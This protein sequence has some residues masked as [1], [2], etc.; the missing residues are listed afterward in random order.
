MRAAGQAAPVHERLLEMEL[1]PALLQGDTREQWEA[2]S[3]LDSFF[4]RVYAYFE[5]R[6]LRC[7]L[8]GRVIQL[9]TLAFTLGLAVCLADA[10]NWEGL[11][12]ECKDEH[13]CAAVQ[14]L[15][16][17]ALSA[18]S[19]FLKLFVGVFALYWLWM[20]L[21]FFWDLRP[22][23]EMRAFYR[24]KLRIV[25][26]DLQVV[27]WDLVVQRVVELQATSRLCI[28]KDQL[29][30]HDIANRILRKEN[31]MVAFVNRGLLPLELPMLPSLNMLT[32]TLEWNVY[33]C[34]LEAMFDSEF[35]IRQSFTQ[36]VTGLRRRLVLT[37]VLNLLLSPFIAA[38]MLIFFFL[39]HAEEFH[40]RPASSAFSRDYSSRARWMMREFNELPHIFEARML[41][42]T[43]DANTYVEQFPAPLL[44][45]VARFV[46]FI[47][48]S[49]VGVLILLSL[50]NERV[51][52]FYLH[53]FNLFWWLSMASVLLAVSRTFSAQ[54]NVSMHPEALLQSVARHTHY[55]PATWRQRGHT[56]QVYEEFARLYQY[57]VLLLLQEILG[58]VITPLLLCFVLPR[59]APD[60]L[61]FVRAFTVHVEGVGH[62]CSLALFDFERHGDVRY[63]APVNGVG[64]QRSCEGKMEK[65]Y[66][67]FKLHHPS[68][69]QAHAG[70]ALLDKISGGSSVHAHLARS[71]HAADHQAQ[72]QAHGQPHA[73]QGQ[74]QALPNA[75]TAS[76]ASH[77]SM[78]NT[79]HHAQHHAQ[80][81]SPHSGGV[82]CCGGHAVIDVGSVAVMGSSLG[83]TQL[84]LLSSSQLLAPECTA[85]SHLGSLIG[86]SLSAR[87]NRHGVISELQAERLNA[88]M[89]ARMDDYYLGDMHRGDGEEPHADTHADAHAD[90]HAEAQD[91]AHRG[92]EA[93]AGTEVMVRGAVDMDTVNYELSPL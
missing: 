38:F 31:F 41:A 84:M 92:R 58:C 70:D 8:A 83:A 80:H 34:I 37:G 82:S 65:S 16:H 53:G 26:A 9:L 68:W 49:L 39:K 67:N 86:A 91:G 14:L 74:P 79:Q 27:A 88:E 50:L 19:P 47:V 7:I 6:G 3:D 23:L 21:H 63:G 66:V 1:D 40:R 11:V 36:D 54:P 52:I 46:T 76:P 15:R 89:Y 10:L 17:D 59:R 12:N 81:L 64:G 18:P 5:E 90:A 20:L 25:D 33:F 72:H 93:H 24:D 28:V 56:R 35:R 60:I 43:P 44:T 13:S 45:L 22:L 61:A 4:S 69:R 55:M 2:I 75:G 62:V 78:C 51:L 77:Q 73:Q 57:R 71:R 29:T 42:S 48:G 32:K 87:P 30:A 85:D